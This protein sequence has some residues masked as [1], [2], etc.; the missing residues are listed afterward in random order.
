[1][2]KLEEYTFTEKK[3]ENCSLL[4]LENKEL[5]DKIILQKS[6]KEIIFNII[7]ELFESKGIDISNILDNINLN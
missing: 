2:L 7:E 1:M 3:L 6:N 5:V 4:L